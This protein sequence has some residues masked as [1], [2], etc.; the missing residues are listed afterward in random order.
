MAGNYAE[1]LRKEGMGMR[2]KLWVRYI[3]TICLYLF[4]AGM[5][6]VGISEK[7]NLHT[8]EVLTYLLAN[9]TYDE[10][11]TLAPEMGKTY[12]PAASP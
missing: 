11:I 6:V 12:D 9:N 7:R 4:L 2:I 3:S 5:I 8:D 10:E 1:N